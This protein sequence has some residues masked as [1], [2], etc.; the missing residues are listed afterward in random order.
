[1]LGLAAIT[2]VA[3]LCYPITNVVGYRSVALL[4]MF[5]VSVLSLRMSL[6]PVLAAA[7]ASALIWNYFF[8]PPQFTFHIGSLEDGLM[9]SMYFIVALFTL[10][11]PVQVLSVQMPNQDE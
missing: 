3:G 7:T 5:V 6:Y 9:F 2:G 11:L 4:L 1:M 8:I 10:R